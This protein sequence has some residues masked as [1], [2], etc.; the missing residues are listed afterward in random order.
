MY[1]VKRLK[2]L[3]EIRNNETIT[4]FIINICNWRFMAYCAAC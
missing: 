4:S 1:L 3:K 2:I